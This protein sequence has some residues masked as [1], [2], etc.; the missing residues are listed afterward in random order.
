MAKVGISGRKISRRVQKDSALEEHKRTLLPDSPLESRD[1]LVRH[2]SSI[3]NIDKYG[4]FSTHIFPFSIL[5]L[6]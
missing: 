1:S 3:D 6:L 4:V 5:M 2:R